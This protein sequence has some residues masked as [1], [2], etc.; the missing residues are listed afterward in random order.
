MQS[1]ELLLLDEYYIYIRDLSQ[2]L[3]KR[4]FTPWKD[5]EMSLPVSFFWRS[6]S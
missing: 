4:V 1:S 5:F 3:E 6:H 2:N